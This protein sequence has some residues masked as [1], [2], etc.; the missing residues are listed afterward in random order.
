MTKNLSLAI[1]AAML[2][3]AAWLGFAH[4]QEREQPVR[5]DPIEREKLS[6]AGWDPDEPVP[7]LI[8]C[9][10]GNKG[11][12]VVIF[13][14]GLGGNKEQYPN[15]MKELASKGLFVVAID[16]H[17][18]GERKVPGIFPQGKTLGR[19]GDDYSIWVHQSAISHT[20]RDISRIID[21]LSA[22]SDVDLSRIGVG[23][24]SMGSCTSMVSAW[25]D[26][27][28]SVVAGLIGA[29]D[30]WWDVTKT[31]PGPEQDAKRNALSPR[32]RQLVNSLNPQDRKTA[33]AP[34]ALFLANGGRDDGIDIE[35]VKTFVKDLQPSYKA[36]P[37]RL[38][39]LEDPKTGHAVTD[40]MWN[41]GIK[42]LIRHLV[43]KPIRSTR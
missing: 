36:H 16:A 34:K 17:L 6:L 43:E 40:R 11:M 24:V 39:L 21:A 31:A 42:W 1:M 20:S 37:D 4:P 12:P 30:F 33:Y 22:R 3:T 27:R 41:E 14:H 23:G 35:S 5:D 25:R 9:K 29:V 19:L 2:C 32:V 10:K 26:P 38:M 18:H 7:A 13:S 28:I 8:Y 15:R